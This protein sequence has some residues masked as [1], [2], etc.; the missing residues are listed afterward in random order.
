MPNIKTGTCKVSH[1]DSGPNPV[2]DSDLEPYLQPDSDSKLHVDVDLD[3]VPDSFQSYTLDPEA[4]NPMKCKT[5]NQT[6]AH[7]R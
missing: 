3:P 2:S 6:K 5:G 1:P 4:S 7:G